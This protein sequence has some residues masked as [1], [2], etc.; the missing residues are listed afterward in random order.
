MSNF[1]VLELSRDPENNQNWFFTGRSFIATS[2]GAS[3]EQL[4]QSDFFIRNF[5]RQCDDEFGS[6]EGVEILPFPNCSNK[7]TI[8]K[9]TAAV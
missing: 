7:P 9:Q 4:K 8:I 1:I 5:S 6:W 3:V 2:T